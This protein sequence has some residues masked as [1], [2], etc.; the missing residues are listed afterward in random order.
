MEGGISRRTFLGAGA[1]AA[2]VPF[3]ADGVAGAGPCDT[4]RELEAALDAD[5]SHLEAIRDERDELSAAIDSLRAT[6]AGGRDAARGPHPY[7]EAAREAART[8]GVEARPGMV[9]L[10][11]TDDVSVATASAWFVDE[12]LLLT[13]NHNVEDLTLSTDRHFWTIDGNRHEF[14]VVDRSAQGP[15]IALLRTDAT[16]PKVLPTGSS[17]A[18]SGGDE[19]VQVGNPGGFGQWVLTLGEF[20]ERDQ[21]FGDLVTS[22][23]GLQGVSGSPLLDMSGRV[24]GV[25]FAGRPKTDWQ[26]GEAPEPV[27]PEVEVYPLAPDSNALHVP[28]EQALELMEEWT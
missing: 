10:E 28:I 18:L 5:R 16:A 24:V 23:P 21:A 12:H 7:D 26:P 9:Y 1:S 17:E 22:V 3:G 14:D 11:M 4:V 27:A 25:T 13:N 6:V 20:L 19:L 15:D 8:V 2:L